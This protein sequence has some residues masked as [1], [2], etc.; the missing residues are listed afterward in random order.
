[1][2]ASQHICFKRLNQFFAKMKIYPVANDSQLRSLTLSCNIANLIF[3]STL[4]M[5]GSGRPHPPENTKFVAPIP[6]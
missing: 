3:H 2:S 1:M 6:T 5:T 4:S